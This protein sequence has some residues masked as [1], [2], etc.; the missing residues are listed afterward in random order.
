M[1]NFPTAYP[2]TTILA[3]YKRLCDGRSENMTKT[4]SA[5]F[6]DTAVIAF[7]VRSG[8][9]DDNTIIIREHPLPCYLPVTLR[10]IVKCDGHIAARDRMG[11]GSEGR[12]IDQQSAADIGM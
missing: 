11:N 2:E 10:V 7:C 6:G 3:E 5:P 9:S 12:Q 4:V 1:L 8:N